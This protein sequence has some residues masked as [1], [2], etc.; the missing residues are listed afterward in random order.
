MPDASPTKWHRAHVTWFF[1]TFLLTP[2]LEDYVADPT[3]GFLFNS[4]Y[5]TVG[6]RHPRPKR[7][8]ITRPSV[9]EVGAY[10]H[11]IDDAMLHLLASSRLD[12]PA[13]RELVVLGLHHEQQHQELLLMD[14]KHVLS[15]TIVK[16][17]YRGGPAAPFAEN[18]AWSWVDFDG[19]IVEIGYDGDDFSFD[20]E[21]PVHETLLR[22]YRLADRL[23]TAGDWQ[24]FMEDGGYERH[25]F[26]LSDG[27]HRIQA[28]EWKAPFYWDRSEDGESWD[29]Y[30]LD[31][32]RPVNPS[33]PVVH[34]SYYEADAF[35]RWAGARLPTE[36]E[37]ESA[38]SGLPLVGNLLPA[39]QLHPVSVSAEETTDETGLRQVYGDVWEWTSSPYIGYPGFSPAAG[40]VGE[41]NGKFMIDQ[42]VLRGGC[43]VTPEGHVRPSYRNFFPAHARWQFGGLRLAADQ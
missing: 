8:L 9:A 19:R 3:F 6:D 39:D 17:P 25:E 20:N 40:A 42:Q 26:W 36:A 13:V 14:I 12:D 5:E 41:Y 18:P 15:S 7:G 43:A 23:V 28:E 2:Y 34:I 31:G 21:Q 37:W 32:Q 33:E 30:T 29:V 24:L 38:A 27:W 35:A 16:S 22:P 10:R 11:R 1:E 4:Y